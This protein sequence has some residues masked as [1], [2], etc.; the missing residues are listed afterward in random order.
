MPEG[1]GAGTTPAL[2]FE[3]VAYRYP[4]ASSPAVT[5]ID[6]E[7]AAGEILAL[8][9]GNGSGKSTLARLA[10]GLLVP[11]AGRVLVAALGSRPGPPRV[12]CTG[13]PGDLW[14]VRAGVGLLFQDPD[15]QIVGATVEDDVAFGLENLG[16]P[17]EEMKERVTGILDIVG[18]AEERRTEVHQLSGGQKQRVALAGVLVL[19]PSVLVLDEPTSMLDALGR[20]DVLDFVRSLSAEGVAVVLITQNMDEVL[21]AH[22]VVALEAGRVGYDGPPLEFF[23]S[24]AGG[25]FPLGEPSALELAIDL[26][27]R[28]GAAM[29]DRDSGSTLPLT[30]D[31]L[32]AAVR[33][34]VGLDRT[35]EGPGLAQEG[36]DRA[37]EGRGGAVRP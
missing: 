2:C 37:L 1:A 34:L 21:T 17:R 6:L 14:D 15:D 33:A 25:R 11:E 35:P 29:W 36:P 32:V 18:L 10:N 8:V 5:G 7:V 20:A 26:R 27:Q 13:S 31:E 23:L 30:E 9:G 4:G 16:V 3:G 24:N 12:L 28:L 22:R 19:R